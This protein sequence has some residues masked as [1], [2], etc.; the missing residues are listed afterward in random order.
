MTKDTL[1]LAYNQPMLDTFKNE[2]QISLGI[3]TSYTL[4]NDPRHILFSLAR[5][6]FCAKMLHGKNRVLEIGCGDALGIGILLQEVQKMHCID[7]EKIVIEDNIKRNEFGERLSFECRDVISS[8]IEEEYDAVISLDVIEHI[9][10]VE[11]NIFLKNI[12]ASLK[13]DGVAIIGTPNA[14]AHCYA[15]PISQAGHI[16]LKKHDELKALLLNYF[17]N[18]FL[19]SMNDEV[20]HTGYHPMGHYI[21]ALCTGY[22]QSQ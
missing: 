15:S 22:K 8:P 4:R 5:Y 17:D 20:L 6:K 13:R 9:P 10:Q 21:M 18:V 2:G 14:T 1:L 3:H 19:F 16:N 12:F 11:E 7:I